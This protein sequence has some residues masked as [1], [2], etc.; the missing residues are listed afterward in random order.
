MAAASGECAAWTSAG[1]QPAVPRAMGCELCIGS[2]DGHK[3]AG[4]RGGRRSGGLRMRGVEEVFDRLLA[5][6]IPSSASRFRP[7]TG[8]TCTRRGFDGSR[9]RARLRETAPRAAEPRNDGKQ[10]PFRGHPVFTAQH[11]TATCCRWLPAISGTPSRPG[12]RGPPPSRPMWSRR[13]AAGCALRAATAPDEARASP[14]IPVE[15]DAPRIGSRTRAAGASARP[16]RSSP[17][18]PSA[19]RRRRI[20]ASGCG[21]RCAR[22]RALQIQLHQFAWPVPSRALQI[23]T[24]LVGSS[25]SRS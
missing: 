20:R 19:D 1:L 17:G 12:R 24:A 21:P 18:P 6:R 23:A 9:A 16:W 13:S 4:Q 22:I 10:T 15:T 3:P 25:G 5:V 8:P 11:A 7:P 2:D 14:A